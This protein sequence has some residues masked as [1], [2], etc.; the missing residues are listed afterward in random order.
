M[1]L[2]EYSPLAL[3]T[4]KQMPTA[5]MN[6]WHAV[7]GMVTEVGELFDAYKKQEIYDKPLDRVNVLE[8]IGDIMWYLNLYA[9]HKGYI[10][11]FTEGFEGGIDDIADRI[12]DDYDGKASHG[13]LSALLKAVFRAYD[14]EV[15]SSHKDRSDPSSIIKVIQVLLAELAAD[16]GSSL[17]VCLDTNIAKL[18]KR[19][20]D[21]YS[22]WSAI[23][24]DVVV[25]R[26][27]LDGA[28]S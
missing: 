14:S 15:L 22:D 2:A 13:M 3:R 10:D 21:K 18:A 24:R 5:Y 26:E 20:G 17:P 11:K 1:K 27:L 28:L 19:Y 8:E 7:V 4:A 23:H 16:L 25:E 9:Y 6:I 12:F